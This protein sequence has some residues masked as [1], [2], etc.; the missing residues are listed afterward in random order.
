M[1][2][3]VIREVGIYHRGV[4]REESLGENISDLVM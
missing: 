2:G 4:A 1:G 3:G